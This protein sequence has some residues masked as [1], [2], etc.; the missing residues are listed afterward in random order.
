LK[1]VWILSA[2]LALAG[3]VAFAREHGDLRPGLIRPGGLPIF[4]DSQGPLA[5]ASLT[6]S[7]IPKDAVP[8]GVVTGESCQYSLS[9]PLSISLRATSISGAIGNG[10]FEKIFKKIAEE[11]PGVR[12]I[13]DVKVDLHAISILGIFGK[14]CTEV[15]AEAYR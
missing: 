13:Y 6:R 4:F 1:P 15:T 10:S 9:V 2:L 12:G 3:P 8:A 11:H 7:E 5:Y 14:L